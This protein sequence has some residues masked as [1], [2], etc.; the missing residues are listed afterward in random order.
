MVRVGFLFGRTGDAA[1]SSVYLEIN[2]VRWLGLCAF[3]AQSR[4]ESATDDGLVQQWD[5]SSG[6]CV[7]THLPQWK[8]F[9]I[10]PFAQ[11]SHQR[12]HVHIA[13]PVGGGASYTELDNKTHL[14]WGLGV[15]TDRAIVKNGPRWAIRVGRNF[16][17]GPAVRNGGGVYAVGGV[18]F[19]LDHPVLLGRSFK[20]M[21][22]LKPKK[23]AS[24]GS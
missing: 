15:S 9:L 18:I 24:P 22:G 6:A 17:A 21:V 19:P 1:G 7:T 8:G 16:G 5:S 11:F 23:D 12:E 14:L 13:I 10:S 2:P 3:A 4:A 20:R